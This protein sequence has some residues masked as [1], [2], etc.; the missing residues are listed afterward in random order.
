M[1]R[2]FIS[3]LILI[4][5]LAVSSC[6][7]QL[8]GSLESSFKTIQITGGSPEFTKILIKRYRQS[9][10]E[11]KNDSAEKTVDIIVD[12]LQKKIL[13]IGSSGEVRE[14]QL[15]YHI[16]YRIKGKN[17]EWG[18]PIKVSST[19]EYTY[20][21]QNIVAKQEEENNL[22]KGMRDQIIR[23]MTSQISSSK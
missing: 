16:S 3:V 13:S 18:S 11:I 1:K 6:G 21:N 14:Y 12:N 19:R 2:L 17:G 23:A 15:N 9:G 22:I 10:V 7:F 20:N 5:T 4:L 8:R